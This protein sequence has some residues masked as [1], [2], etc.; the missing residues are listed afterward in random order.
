M[1]VLIEFKRQLITFL[2]ELIGQFP[3][4]GDLVIT[5]L[6]VSNQMIIKDSIDNFNHS[7]NKN[8][9]E[10]RKMVQERNESLI[11][12]H[13]IFDK[14]GKTKVNHFKTIWRSGCLDADDKR[15]IWQW[16]DTFVYLGDK[17]AKTMLKRK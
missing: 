17:Y 10:L 1:E 14:L 9:Q 3:L 6:F 16:I 15:V 7:I 4:E 12:D 8:K 2:D 13:N 5:R 11:L